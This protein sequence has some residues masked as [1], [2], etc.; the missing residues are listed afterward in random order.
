MFSNF[1]LS[2]PYPTVCGKVDE[3]ELLN[4]YDLTSGRFSEM[5]ATCGYVYQ[6]IICGD[7]LHHLFSGLAVTEMQHV[8]LL[9]QAIKIF[10]GDPVF[11][12]KHN[13]F[14]GSYINYE[15]NLKQIFFNNVESEKQAI[16]E[17]TRVAENTQNQSLCDLLTRIAMD[18]QLH[19]QLLINA[20]YEI[21]NE[22]FE[23]IEV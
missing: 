4:L 9:M 1:S 10:G 13:Y 11:A 2:L 21:F 8:E 17:Y 15:K 19:E 3:K 23:E 12:G 18:E 5:S 20:Y 7:K 22:N 14:S 6:S 16:K